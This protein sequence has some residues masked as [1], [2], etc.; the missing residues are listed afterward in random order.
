[1][2]HNRGR[3]IGVVMTV[4]LGLLGPMP[5]WA[6]GELAV[7]DGTTVSLEYTL[8]LPD[9]TRVESNVGQQPLV[10]TQ[11]SGHLVPGLEKALLGMKAGQT[12]HVEVPAALAYGAYN[13]DAQIKVP[14]NRVPPTVKVGDMLTRPSDRQPLK[15][16]E[17]TA[18]T[19]IMDTN[20]P[21]AG[22]DLI[23]DVKV[24]KVER[25]SG[26]P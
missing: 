22:K 10:F 16:L 18:D 9:R 15:V 8:T 21:L 20:H 26:K 5:S 25:A 23:F 1:M 7:A 14:R 3:L 13:A 2:R 12:K 24:L 17:I 11:G 19:V 6:A 4:T